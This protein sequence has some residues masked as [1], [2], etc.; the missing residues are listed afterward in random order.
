MKQLD[1]YEFGTQLLQTNDLDPV[2]VMLWEAKLP[3]PTLERWLMA[4]WAFYHVGTASWIA[5]KS[6]GY[7]DRFRA[8]AASKEYPRSSE[9]R[10]FRGKL[11]TKSTEWL[12]T[13]GLEGL[14]HPLRSRSWNATKLINHVKR[15]YGFGD[16]IAFKVADM[17]DRLGLNAVQFTQEHLKLFD[18]PQK[19]ADLL[20]LEEFGNTAEETVTMNHAVNRLTKYFNKFKAPPRYERPVGI[21]EVETI[22]CKWKSYRGG[23]YHVGEDIESLR[24]G[25][26]RFYRCSLSQELIRAARRA[27]LGN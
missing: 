25:L 10:H 19:G 16:W 9:R 6:S 12:A 5:D 17:V 26:L 22:L 8:A 14:F 27:K 13:E 20:Y 21:Q 3:Q 23:H 2:Y 7:W 11:S 4:Y 15:W 1:V 18:S 24:N